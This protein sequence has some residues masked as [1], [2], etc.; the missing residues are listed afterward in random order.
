MVTTV[1]SCRQAAPQDTPSAIPQCA[2]THPASGARCGREADHRG[3]LHWVS[4]PATQENSWPV[5][6]G[7]QETLVSA[8]EGAML[9]GVSRSTISGWVKSGRIRPA[10]HRGRVA[11]YSPGELYRAQIA[12]RVALA[13]AGGSRKQRQPRVVFVPISVAWAFTLERGWHV[14]E[15]P[16]S[17]IDMDRLCD[18]YDEAEARQDARTWWVRDITGESYGPY[19]EEAALSV[20][21][22]L[23]LFSTATVEQV[24]ADEVTR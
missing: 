3:N 18:Q 8:A 4:Y 24:F 17:A 14:I 15:D 19:T 23:G 10:G 6:Y 16:A 13:N 7:K 20:R 12:A 11:L 2:E 9:L 1:P 21:R 22:A 5:A